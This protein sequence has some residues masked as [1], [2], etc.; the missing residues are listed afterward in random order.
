[1]YRT[2]V[3]RFIEDGVLR[4]NCIANRGLIENSNDD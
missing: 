4:T 2:S 3:G 1:M